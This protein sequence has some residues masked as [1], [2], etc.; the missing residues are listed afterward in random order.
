MVF[1]KSIEYSADFDIIEYESSSALMR[2][3][4][5]NLKALHDSHRNSYHSHIIAWRQHHDPNELTVF[6]LFPDFEDWLG[7][8]LSVPT[9]Q[10]LIDHFITSYYAI[11]SAG[12]PESQ[13]MYRTR[14]MQSVS[15][16][17]ISVSNDHTYDGAKNNC[18]PNVKMIWNCTSSELVTAYSIYCA[19]DGLEE[20]VH[21]V[22]EVSHRFGWRPCRNFT[23]TW[24]NN[25]HFWS[26][27]WWFSQ[28]RLGIFHWMK[29]IFSTMPHAHKDFHL[30]Q[31]ALMISRC[32]YYMN[33][34]DVANVKKAVK[35][36]HLG[37][38]KRLTDDHE[39]EKY[40]RNLHSSPRFMRQFGKYINTQ[41][42]D[43]DTMRAN[44]EAWKDE[45]LPKFDAA[46]GLYLRGV[47]SHHF[48]LIHANCVR[49]C[50]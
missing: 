12:S 5:E 16:C 34:Q 50:R 17:G 22:E 42:Y 19:G 7:R 36:G 26:H 43:E 25:E 29:R 27:I 18:D 47:L 30:A 1:G 4:E 33:P 41:T 9:C 40:W 32:I 37:I 24:P 3:C 46:K 15:V 38:K 10:T 31:A 11:G 45:Y 48:K 2:K 8:N 6:D 14:Q 35:A 20:C 21:A 28:G 44:V 49:L 23:D 39:F 13:H